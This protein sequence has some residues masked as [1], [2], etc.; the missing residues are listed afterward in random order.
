[1]KPRVREILRQKVFGRKFLVTDLA[2]AYYLTHGYRNLRP[3]VADWRDTIRMGDVL[4][5]GE[6]GAFR[7]V[8]YCNYKQNNILTSVSFI[9]RHCSWTGRCYTYLTRSDL[10]T[11]SKA[12]F[13]VRLD[14]EF[15][16]KMAAEMTNHDQ[17]TFS[18]C[19]V[20]GIA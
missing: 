1:M 14:Q 18:C 19:D 9:I 13:R 12:G 10:K 11:Y 8:R 4:R 5:I 3:M 7:V 2:G 20:R 17:Y 6:D 16:A 15:D